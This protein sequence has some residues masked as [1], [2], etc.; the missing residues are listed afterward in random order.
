MQRLQIRRTDLPRSGADTHDLAR[1]SRSLARA[2][3]WRAR[4]PPGT[5]FEFTRLVLI[6]SFACRVKPDKRSEF[7]ASVGDLMDRVRWLQGC[8]DCLLVADVEVDGAYTLLCGWRDR[9][10]LDR[11]LQTCRASPSMKS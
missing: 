8:L 6:G 5:G 4:S 7:C 3:T 1:H 9:A 2:G 10:G 11:F